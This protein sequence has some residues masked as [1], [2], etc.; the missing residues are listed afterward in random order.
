MFAASK[1]GD[2]EYSEAEE[3]LRRG[4]FWTPTSD[5]TTAGGKNLLAMTLWSW[6]KVFGA[7]LSEI[8]V[9]EAIP[10]VDRLASICLESVIDIRP[11]QK[12]GKAF[13]QQFLKAH[14]PTEIGRRKRLLREDT[15]GTLPPGI[16]VLIAQGSADNVV[17]P[18]ITAVYAKSLCAASA[19]ARSV[20]PPAKPSVDWIADRFAGKDA[21][22]DCRHSD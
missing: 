1:L 13:Q 9:P 16:P 18:P 6:D 2:V 14:N 8:V 4:Q 3:R 21:P 5:I 7:P 12:I 19:T 15:I 20:A 10:E 22:S 11:R 17:D